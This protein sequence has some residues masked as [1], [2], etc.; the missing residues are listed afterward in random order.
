MLGRIPPLKACSQSPPQRKV[1][2]LETD[3]HQHPPLS[4]P[5]QKADR[6]DD[7][8]VI[9]PILESLFGA[10]WD[11][12][13]SIKQEIAT[14]VKDIRRGVGELDQKVESMEQASDSHDEKIIE[15]SLDDPSPMGQ[16]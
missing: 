5:P 7:A 10:L 15:T 6:D 1:T 11:D 16:N 14:D 9:R 3:R 2:K 4:S 8:P 13:A 12:I